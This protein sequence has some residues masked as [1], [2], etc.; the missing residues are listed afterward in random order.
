[1]S[2]S[3]RNLPQYSHETRSSLS[4]VLLTQA[5]A[6]QLLKVTTR[7]IRRWTIQGRLQ[8]VHLGSRTVR[9]TTDSILAFIAA[10]NE[11][12]PGWQAELDGKGVTAPSHEQ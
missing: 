3:V 2:A 7:T 8:E 4:G 5:E 11:V 12:E 6:A 9:Y 1:M 10:S